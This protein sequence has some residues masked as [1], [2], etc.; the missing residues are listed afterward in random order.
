M[1]AAA[2]SLD[3]LLDLVRPADVSRVDPHGR[4]ARVDRPEREARVEVDVRDH[5]DRRE[6]HDLPQRLGVLDLRHSAP[7]DLAA[8]RCER[9][10]LR[11]RGRH[12]VRRRQRHRLHDDGSAAADLDVADP[13]RA[14]RGHQLP[15][16]SDV[17]READEEEEQHDRYPDRRHPLVHLSADRLTAH[18]LD[19]RE[20]DVP[21]VE[22]QQRQEV[23][24]GERKAQEAEHPEVGLRPLLERLRGAFHD[25][26]RARNFLAL[27][28]DEPGER[29]TDLSSDRPCELERG[30]GRAAARTGDPLPW[31]PWPEVDGRVAALDGQGDRPATS[32]LDQRRNVVGLHPLPVDADD[33][34]ARLQAICR[35]GCRRAPRARPARSS[36]ARSRAGTAAAEH[37]QRREEEDREQE[38]RAGAGEDDRHLLPG[39][40][41]PVR[42]TAEAVLISFD[43]LA[44]RLRAPLLISV[45]AAPS[46]SEPVRAPSMSP[47][48]SLRSTRSSGP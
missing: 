28:R 10:D 47:S 7:H 22:R 43:P 23:Q 3:D 35:R 12:V 16:R 24:E 31:A 40:L 5:R 38:V 27:T 8:G 34:V 11:C 4:D 14:L 48:S 21:S 44:R 30:P 36:R 19:D 26:D 15:S 41:A 6:A 9:R 39:P 20:R 46:S 17:V 18:S 37:E 25:P 33:L 13:D 45:S 42:V 29:R 1:P 32:V 2:R